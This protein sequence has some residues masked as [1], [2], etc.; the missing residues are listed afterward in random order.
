VALHFEVS[1]TGIGIEPDQVQQLFEPF[2]QVDAS[3]ARR[4]GGSGLGLAIVKRL[5]QLMGGEVSLDS[6]PGQGST[7]RWSVRCGVAS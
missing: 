3:I 6:V 2:T 4:Y 5:V 7:V 1:D